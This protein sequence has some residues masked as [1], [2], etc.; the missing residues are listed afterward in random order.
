MFK[1]L[2]RITYQVDDINKAKQW[3]CSVLNSHMTSTEMEHRY[4]TLKDGTLVEKA[5][6]EFRLLYGEKKTE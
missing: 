4:L 2:K 1:P 3:Y 5:I 6:P